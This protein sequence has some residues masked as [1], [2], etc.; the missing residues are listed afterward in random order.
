[1]SLEQLYLEK[2]YLENKKDK[3]DRYLSPDGHVV[4]REYYHRICIA[5]E[6]RENAINRS[7]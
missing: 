1:M 5:V 3:L 7:N 4:Y 6:V 2:T